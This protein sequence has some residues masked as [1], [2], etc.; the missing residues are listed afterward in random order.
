MQQP[1]PDVIS[2]PFYLLF[3]VVVVVVIV[4]VFVFFL[5]LLLLPLSSDVTFFSLSFMLLPLIL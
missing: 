1:G 5:L 2:F 3:F 4:V